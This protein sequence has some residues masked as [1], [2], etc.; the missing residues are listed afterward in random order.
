MLAKSSLSYVVSGGRKQLLYGQLV[1]LRKCFLRKWL[2]VKT[3]SGKAHMLGT[4]PGSA[5][6]YYWLSGLG[7]IY[8][9]KDQTPASCMQRMCLSQ[10]SYLSGPRK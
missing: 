2:A 1:I 7:T 3:L 5:H 4:I 10:L 6:G 9:D 8:N